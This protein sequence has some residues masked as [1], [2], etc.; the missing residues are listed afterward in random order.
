MPTTKKKKAGA[1]SPK[2]AILLELPKEVTDA[3]NTLIEEAFDGQE[4]V[5]YQGEA[6]DLILKNFAAS[7][8]KKYGEGCLPRV[9]QWI[10][11]KG[12][13]NVESHYEAVGWVVD[14]DKPGYNED[15]EAKF[16]FTVKGK[17]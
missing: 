5:I 9:R 3:F 11:D 7:D 2:E 14:Y 13:L 16:I 4:A 15:Y 17:R 1:I 12:Y 10:F 8:A 6:V